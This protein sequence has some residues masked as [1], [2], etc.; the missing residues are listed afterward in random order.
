MAIS[1][2]AGRRV[3]ITG[4]GVVSSLG[5]DIDTF[6]NNLIAGR[7]GIDKITLFDT[8]A[9]DC[10]VAAEVRDFNP[11]PSFPNPKELRRT[12]RFTQFGVVAGHKALIDSGLDLEKSNRDEIG[13][14]IG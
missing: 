10:Q 5:H 9:Y 3:V 14:F 6:W 2:T 13:A 12:D 8:S 7:C 4:L 1:T 11:L